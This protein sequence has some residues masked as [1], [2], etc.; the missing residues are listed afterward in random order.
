MLWVKNTIPL[1]IGHSISLFLFDLYTLSAWGLKLRVLQVLHI[2]ETMLRQAR[3]TLLI[4]PLF[5]LNI[6]LF[7]YYTSGDTILRSL[8]SLWYQS[9]NFK[10]Y[11][12]NFV[13][14]SVQC[15]DTP[16]SGSASVRVLNGPP[17]A[18]FRGMIYLTSESKVRRRLIKI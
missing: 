10:L 13:P 17:T 14:I 3:A 8:W 5:S 18:R 11:N 4:F 1:D 15:C 6:S 2:S 9:S 7:Y 12:L 16:P